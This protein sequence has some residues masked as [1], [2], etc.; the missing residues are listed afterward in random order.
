M[1]VVDDDTWPSPDIITISYF[2]MKE[3]ID[4]CY[5]EN[6]VDYIAVLM[7]MYWLNYQFD[8]VLLE[9]DFE[10]APS[11]YIIYDDNEKLDNI[12]LSN[13]VINRLLSLT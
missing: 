4:L 10:L 3:Q 2:D 11:K 7:I 6:L 8:K 13:Y 5:L 9:I 12:F 1:G